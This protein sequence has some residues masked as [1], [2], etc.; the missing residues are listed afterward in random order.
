MRAT[1]TAYLIVRIVTI[2]SVLLRN[3]SYTFITYIFIGIRIRIKEFIRRQVTLNLVTSS[4][5]RGSVAGC[6]SSYC[7]VF[8]D[9]CLLIRILAAAARIKKLAN[10]LRKATSDLRKWVAQYTG[11][12]ASMQWFWTLANLS[13]LNKYYL[14]ITLPL[15]YLFIATH[16]AFYM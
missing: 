8:K 10:Q 3:D 5:S 12:D 7:K 13:F 15:K 4:E 1:C 2:I 11:V 6:S 14:N 9:F 16:K